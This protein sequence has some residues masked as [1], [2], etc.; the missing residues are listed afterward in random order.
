[1]AQPSDAEEKVVKSDPQ[2]TENNTAQPIPR[3]KFFIAIVVYNIILQI[4]N[5]IKVVFVNWFMDQIIPFQ[6]AVFAI[7]VAVLGIFITAKLYY[8][9]KWAYV[10]MIIANVIALF[11]YL[12]A[13][14]ATLKYQGEDSGNFEIVAVII[15]I[16]G[17][18]ATI[19]YLARK[20]TRKMFFK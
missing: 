20:N 14:A 17:A 13:T 11:N 6:V 5:F 2:S 18:L 1:M 4:Y 8:L 12:V 19:I 9:K 7:I 3:P 10:L 15:M 16:I